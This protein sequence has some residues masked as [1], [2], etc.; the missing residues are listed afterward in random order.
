MSQTIG[1]LKNT[2]QELMA[3]WLCNVKSMCL[4]RTVSLAHPSA[5]TMLN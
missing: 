2:K 3:I 1:T 4:P 5:F